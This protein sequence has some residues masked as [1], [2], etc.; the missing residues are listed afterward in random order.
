MLKATRRAFVNGLINNYDERVRFLH[1][2]K[3][4]DLSAKTIPKMTKIET[5]FMAKMAKQPYPLG[6]P[7]S[8]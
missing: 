3:I 1:K 4:Q 6:L 5:I 7:I 8:T 2:K